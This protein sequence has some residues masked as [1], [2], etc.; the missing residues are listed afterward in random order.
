VNTSWLR[1]KVWFLK[2]MWKAL[3][4]TRILSSVYQLCCTGFEPALCWI[5][6]EPH[7]YYRGGIKAQYCLRFRGHGGQCLASINH[8]GTQLPTYFTPSPREQRA[9]RP[10]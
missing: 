8:V 7:G 9:G 2:Y 4:R 5:P 10:S 6:A 3:V 1:L